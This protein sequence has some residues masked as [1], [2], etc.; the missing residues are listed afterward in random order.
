M[1]VVDGGTTCELLLTYRGEFNNDPYMDSGWMRNNYHCT[2]D[3]AGQYTYLIVHESDPRFFLP[4]EAMWGS[5][6]AIVETASGSGNVLRTDRVE[7]P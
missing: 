5:W 7:H 3:E 2:G 6:K 1:T 4:G